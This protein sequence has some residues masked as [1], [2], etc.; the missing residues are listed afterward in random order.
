[1]FYDYGVLKTRLSNY[2][3]D[4]PAVVTLRLWASAPLP[5]PLKITFDYYWTSIY[6]DNPYNPTRHE[7]TYTLELEAGKAMAYEYLFDVDIPMLRH[8]IYHIDGYYTR[9]GFMIVEEG[10]ISITSV[11]DPPSNFVYHLAPV[12]VTYRG[13]QP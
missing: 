10:G 3:Y 1:M 6:T 8:P 5:A 4:L 13:P 7:E 12:R 11:S 9:D 2:E